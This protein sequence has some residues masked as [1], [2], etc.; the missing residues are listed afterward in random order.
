MVMQLTLETVVHFSADE[1]NERYS[2][3]SVAPPHTGTLR[4][5]I[6]F[7]ATQICTALL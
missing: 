4:S 7:Q 6:W 5:E 1:A 3:R 2:R